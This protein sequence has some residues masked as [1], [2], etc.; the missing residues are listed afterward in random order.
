MYKI[1]PDLTKTW[2]LENISQEAIF[3]KYLGIPIQTDALFASPLR[4]DK[5]P[6]CGFKYNVNGKLR[7]KDFSGHFWGDCFDLV[8]YKL[9]ID[10]NTKIGFNIILENIAQ[11]FNLHKYSEGNY[12]KDNIDFT[13]NNYSKKIKGKA[14]IEIKIR[15]WNKFDNLYWNKY[16]IGQKALT[17]FNVFP[18][19]TVWL[20]KGITYTYNYKDLAYAYYFGNGE[21][22]IYYPNRQNLRFISNTSILQGIN[23]LICG[24]VCIITK[25]YK[26]VIALKTFGI[27]SVAPSSETNLISKQNYNFIKERYDFIFSLMD[28]DNTGIRMSRLLEKTYNI[29]PIYFTDKLWN[30][31][32]GL[33]GSKDLTDYIEKFGINNSRELVNNTITKYEI[34]FEEYDTEMNEKLKWI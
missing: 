30:R 11:V 14:I 3:E 17:F 33:N 25:S 27:D 1:L 4:R 34:I 5:N 24:R 13:D 15:N 20:N 31:K 21:Y 12:I 29:E 16:N 7:L 9:N 19:E 10:A 2:L 22:K 23:K 6:T 18:C 28:Y 8:G 32:K 26:D